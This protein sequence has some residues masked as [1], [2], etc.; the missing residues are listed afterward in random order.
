MKIIRFIVDH[1]TALL[2]VLT[3][4]FNL[5]AAFGLQLTSEQVGAINAFLGLVVA[6]LSESVTTVSRNVV[7]KV[8][9]GRVLAGPAAMEPTG[10]DAT[11][12]AVDGDLVAHVAVDQARL[13]A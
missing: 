10:Q 8:T 1:S 11:V 3:A 13:A 2:A 4:G 12:V 9:G 7:A 6:L 5:L